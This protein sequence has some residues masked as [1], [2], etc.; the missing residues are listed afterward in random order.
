MR[1]RFIIFVAFKSS[2]VKSVPHFLNE[3][4]FSKG[5]IYRLFPPERSCRY[6]SIERRTR[7]KRWD[8][9]YV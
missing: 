7:L 5:K 1:V 6:G 9:A 3:G 4:R 8:F 2:S